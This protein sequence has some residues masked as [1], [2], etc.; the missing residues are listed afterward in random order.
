MP[1]PSRSYRNFSAHI[2]F[3]LQTL[4]KLLN[5]PKV[6]RS[7]QG[8]AAGLVSFLLLLV[9]LIVFSGCTPS[10]SALV[11]P[12]SPPVFVDDGD[13]EGL[14]TAL[15]HQLSYLERLQ[16]GDDIVI[17]TGSYTPEELKESLAAF[18]NIINLDLPTVERDRLIREQFTIYQ[19]AGRSGSDDKEMLVTGYYEPILEGNLER[20]SPF[21]Y[22]LYSVPDD[23]VVER[24]ASGQ[25][26]IGRR[27]AA[28]GT[29]LHP[30]WTRAEI[31]SSSRLRGHELV[32][33]KDRFDAFLLHVQGSGKIQLP[34]GEIRAVR[35]HGNNGHPYRSIGKLLVDR[36]ILSLAETDVP[37]IRDHLG[38]STEREVAEI[39][40]HNRRYIFF[41]WGEGEFPDGS[42][43][44]PLTPGRSIAI[45]GK[46]LPMQ[47]IAYLVTRRPVFKSDGSL[48]H[49]QPLRRF[50]LPQDTG[51][52][53]VG[54]GRVDFFYGPGKYAEKAAGIMKEEGKLYFLIKKF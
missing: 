16:G 8:K 43:G 30:Y 1:W 38:S 2:P 46:V 33:L 37:A 15:T 14:H 5:M 36:G 9:G 18:H 31:D 23:L 10:S 42:L 17:A 20:K 41:D 13:L 52:A 53:I 35:Y 6:L 25:Q 7:R 28:T 50:V 49:W 47:T 12:G 51:S 48:S 44:L 32:Y 22:P 45:D 4:E 27:D 39:L 34:D 24:S 26:R 54:T 3:D 29:I 40:Y 19:A 21:I 11:T